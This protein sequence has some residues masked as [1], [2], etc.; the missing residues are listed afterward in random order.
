MFKS[1]LFFVNKILLYFL[2]F[3][4]L[5]ILFYFHWVMIG[6]QDFFF[7]CL[8]YFFPYSLL[9]SYFLHLFLGRTLVHEFPISYSHTEWYLIFF[10]KLDDLLDWRVTCQNLTILIIIMAVFINFFF[11]NCYLEYYEFFMQQTITSFTSN[12]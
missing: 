3:P 9:S 10:T 7:S 1:I 2:F 6:H 8:L 4:Y 5:I 11:N 12:M